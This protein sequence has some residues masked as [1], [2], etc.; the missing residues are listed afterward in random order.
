MQTT[1]INRGVI[2][3]KNPLSTREF[4]VLQ[5][6]AKGYC[7]SQISERLFVPTSQIRLDVEAIIHKLGVK[8][9]IQA[10]AVLQCT[11]YTTK[12]H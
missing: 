5:F 9:R 10:V 12:N 8:N 7:N 2:T 3:L 6:L 11:K 1:K 4:I